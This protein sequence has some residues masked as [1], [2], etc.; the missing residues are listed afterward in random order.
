M[1]SQDSIPNGKIID[2]KAHAHSENLL[3][4]EA[5]T[6]KNATIHLVVILIG[7]D[8]ASLVYI[9]RK[10]I[11]CEDTLIK[12]SLI[13]LPKTTDQNE[14]LELISKYNNDPKVHGILVQQP[15]PPHI[16]KNA[17]VS[18][19]NP[20]KDVDCLNPY[21]VGLSLMGNGKLLPCTPAGILT[22]LERENVPLKGKHAV[23][24]GRSDIVGKPLAFLLLSKD[25]TVTICHSHTKN[26]QEVCN[27]A[28]VLIVAVGKPKLITS[29]FVKEGAIV[30]DVGVNRLQGKKICGDVDF[31]DVKHKT[32]YITP[33]PGGV[34]PM[35]VATLLKNCLRAWELQ[36]PLKEPV[37]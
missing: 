21:N 29:K 30:I 1:Q 7:E 37:V 34:G 8:P 14:A 18:A 6:M 22:L 19:I 5:I 26:L 27:N 36:N 10:R 16:D 2:G 20:L 15:L 24:V 33:V 31:E 17:I 32:S 11:A 35:T 4:R 3:T 13:T 23:I 9:N 25:M 12:F 28:D